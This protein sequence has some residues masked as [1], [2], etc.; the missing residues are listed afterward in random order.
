MGSLFHPARGIEIAD[1]RENHSGDVHWE[2]NHLKF[3][4]DSHLADRY[5][6]QD[7]DRGDLERD[8]PCE[9]Y[10]IQQTGETFVPVHRAHPSPSPETVAVEERKVSDAPGY[11]SHGNLPWEADKEECPALVV[12]LS[13]LQTADGG[14]AHHIHP[15]LVHE[16]GLVK[17]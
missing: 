4:V 8:S 16:T 14:P 7:A 13:R 9:A 3:V 12:S 6:A 15:Y 10:L 5:H 17:A 11:V 2:N 1:H